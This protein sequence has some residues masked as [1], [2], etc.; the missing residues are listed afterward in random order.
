MDEI[1]VSTKNSLAKGRLRL[2]WES[3]NPAAR[4]VFGIFSAGFVFTG[5]T[6]ALGQFFQIRG[7]QH[8]LTSRIFL[9]LTVL[10]A[11][12]GVWGV[13]WAF[14]Y[15]WRFPI[16]GIGVAFG[17]IAWV[18]IDRI[19]PMP[20]HAQDASSQTGMSQPLTQQQPSPVDLAEELAK[21]LKEQQQARKPRVPLVKQHGVGA[22]IPFGIAQD[23]WG[24]VRAEIP[25][26]N[27]PVS[28]HHGPLWTT[29]MDLAEIGRM[30]R[31]WNPG[32][33]QQ[34][35]TDNEIRDFLT[36]LIRYYLLRSILELGNAQTF[37]S[38]QL[39]VAGKSG[40]TTTTTPAI[41]IP[42]SAIYP[43]EDID[44]L[45]K[46]SEFGLLRNEYHFVWDTHFHFNLNVPAGSK[47]TLT[48]DGLIIKKPSTYLLQLKIAPT[49][50][51]AALPFDF[52]PVDMNG[53]NAKM[54]WFTYMFNINQR[55]EWSGDYSDAPPYTEWELALFA[56]IEKRFKQE[57][58]Q[59]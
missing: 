55:F 8:M 18:V 15:K 16:I 42:E 10:F 52:I 12:L 19:F 20:I 51:N 26:E 41:S 34:P 3:S 39:N 22:S 40:G 36:K 29:Y 2:K 38:Y 7:V 24:Q 13:A 21:R 58:I 11:L 47:I 35:P 50:K 37:F 27:M 14:F 33:D 32:T 6:W 28:H 30:Q 45:L 46:E 56:G 43:K 57:E 59:P 53:P 4:T 54:Q 17:L 5:F 48:K 23:H 1:V 31:P 9:A 44:V 49:S 25:Y